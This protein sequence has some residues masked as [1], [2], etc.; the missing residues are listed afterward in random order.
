ML[1]LYLY[2]FFFL[3]KYIYI[4]SKL[5]YN[6]NLLHQNILKE[7]EKSEYY[8]VNYNNNFKNNDNIFT[9]FYDLLLF[10]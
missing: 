2:N 7:I 8:L 10:F 4:L 5:I 6:K 9:F 1:L 3:L